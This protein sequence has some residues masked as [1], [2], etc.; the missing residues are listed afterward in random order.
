M[1]PLNLRLLRKSDC[2]I[3]RECPSINATDQNTLIVQGYVVGVNDVA[4]AGFLVRQ[5]WTAVDVPLSLVPELR[6]VAGWPHLH[7]T[8]R[9]T[10]LVYG[11]ELTDAEALAELSIPPGEAAVEL[12]VSS[13]PL[14]E[15]LNRA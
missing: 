3:G 8:G 7:V 9:D 15:A 1:S 13:L 6:D 10:V 11:P 12:P 14:K 2:D 5:G 4:A